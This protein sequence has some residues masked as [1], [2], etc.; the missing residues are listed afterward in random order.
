MMEWETSSYPSEASSGAEAPT[1]FRTVFF[2]TRYNIESSQN[3]TNVLEAVGLGEYSGK[4][5]IFISK[6]KISCYESNKD[7]HINFPFS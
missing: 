5:K 6:F 4:Q 2:R 1:T 3:L 7:C